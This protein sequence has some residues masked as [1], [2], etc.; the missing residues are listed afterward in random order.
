MT[1]QGNMSLGVPQYLQFY[2]NMA[3]MLPILSKIVRILWR[4]SG[5]KQ[6]LDSGTG[7]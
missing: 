3:F 2:G 1:W 5:S 7:E 6:S 4:L